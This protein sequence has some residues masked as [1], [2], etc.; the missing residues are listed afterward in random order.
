MIVTQ[1]AAVHLGN[2]C[3][4]NLHSTKSAT[5][6]SETIVRWNKEVGQ[7]KDRNSWYIPDRLARKFSEKDD[8]VDGPGSSAVNSESPC[9]LRFSIV[10]GKSQ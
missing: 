9:I 6:N 8:S 3:L 4:G 2:D 7:R 5:Q 10:H 1:Q